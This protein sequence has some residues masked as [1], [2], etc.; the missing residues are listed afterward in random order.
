MLM[1]LFQ[2]LWSWMPVSVFK[3]KDVDSCS[4]N[5]QLLGWHSLLHGRILKSFNN[6]ENSMNKKTN[7][8][9][10]SGNNGVRGELICISVGK[11]ASKNPIWRNQ[12]VQIPHGCTWCGSH[13]TQ[14]H[15][16]LLK[17]YYWYIYTHMVNLPM[18]VICP[19]LEGLLG[20][21]SRWKCTRHGSPTM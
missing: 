19:R 16:H 1:S 14:K 12:W 17:G 21:S 10:N 4:C 6:V 8:P 9:S 2:G 7:A 5:Q 15:A 20:L 13:A 3:P 11:A 18:V